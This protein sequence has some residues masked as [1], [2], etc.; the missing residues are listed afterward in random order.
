[1]KQALLPEGEKFMNFTHLSS[2]I[3]IGSVMIKNRMFM[4]PK[5]K[6]CPLNC[7]WKMAIIY[8]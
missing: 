1:M 2:P 4:V 5:R 6:N 8:L 3:K 7:E